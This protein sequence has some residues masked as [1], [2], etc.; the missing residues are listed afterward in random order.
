MRCAFILLVSVG[1]SEPAKDAA[2]SSTRG[3]GAS[4]SGSGSVAPLESAAPT[5][6]APSASSTASATTVAPLVRLFETAEV[7]EA[8]LDPVAVYS[9]KQGS[10]VIALLPKDYGSRLSLSGEGL[11]AVRVEKPGVSLAALK[12]SVLFAVPPRELQQGE[13]EQ[14]CL[15]TSFHAKTWS[16][17]SD[18]TGGRVWKG[19][20]THGS[21]PTPREAL[22]FD[23]TVDGK[24]IRACASWDAERP[25][26]ERE[27]ASILKSLRK[28]TAP[29]NDVNGL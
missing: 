11:T 27:A 3:T 23:G 1:C 26:L 10:G 25:E 17:S 15:G 16:P 9:R 12:I 2:P 20:G 18:V 29:P 19:V 8:N 13:L 7:R 14:A 28:G 21:R 6:S 24:F 5:P 4:A 22:V